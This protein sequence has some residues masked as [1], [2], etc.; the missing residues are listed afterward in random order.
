MRLRAQ[1]TSLLP[2]TCGSQVM[3]LL[4][5]TRFCPTQFSPPTPL[6]NHLLQR[7]AELGA[8]HTYSSWFIMKECP[9]QAL[10]RGRSRR[11]ANA[12][13]SIPVVM[14]APYSC[15]MDVFTNPEVLHTPEFRDFY[16]GFI[17]QAQSM[18]STSQ[19]IPSPLPRGW[20]GQGADSSKFLIM[21]PTFW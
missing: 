13:A 14:G 8:A 21:T 20:S 12:R 18:N 6:V 4:P 1:S 9:G 10:H 19:L 2:V 15:H 16:G 17:P 5:V 3:S 7:F 11:I